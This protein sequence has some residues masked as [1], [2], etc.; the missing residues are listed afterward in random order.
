M[1]SDV[2]P[3]ASRAALALTVI[4]YLGLVWFVSGVVRTNGVVVVG[5][6]LALLAFCLAALRRGRRREPVRC[7]HTVRCRNESP[8]RCGRRP[9][10]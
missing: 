10:R 6:G 1:A 4:A 2:A 3:S 9:Q 5:V 7:G 8:W